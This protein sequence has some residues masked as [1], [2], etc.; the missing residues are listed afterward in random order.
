MKEKS[1]SSRRDIRLT[2]TASRTAGNQ[3]ES[4]FHTASVSVEPHVEI[5]SGWWFSQDTF[6]MLQQ[7][8]G[9]FSSRNELRHR[10]Q[11]TVLLKT[12][13][14]RREKSGTSLPESDI[15]SISRGDFDARQYN[16]KL[17]HRRA[18]RQRMEK[19]TLYIAVL[20][21]A[22]S[23]FLLSILTAMISV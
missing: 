13:Q 4:I 16:A 2:N 11:A 19:Y 12:K 20:I 5:P 22:V 14:C 23:I 10:H 1:S 8:S 6:V 7:G 17:L 9:L 15:W 18:A 21:A 3:D